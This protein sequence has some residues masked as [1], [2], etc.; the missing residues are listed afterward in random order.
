VFNLRRLA[1]YRN[2]PHQRTQVDFGGLP[3]TQG[4]QYI[5]FASVYPQGWNGRVNG[6]WSATRS[7]ST[8]PY[9]GFY[10]SNTVLD[11][12]NLSTANWW[13]AV[14]SPEDFDLLGRIEFSNIIVPVPSAAILGI[15]GLVTASRRLRKTRA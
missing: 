3:L 13:G 10:Y 9:D 6:K 4:E 11:F 8:S 14:T 5:L 12:A 15:L 7:D 1:I 2:G